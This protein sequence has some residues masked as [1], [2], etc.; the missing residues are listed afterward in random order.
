MRKERRHNCEQA[1]IFNIQRFSLHDGPGIRT[2]V[3]MKGCPLKCFWCANPESQEVN[4]NL[5][6]RNIQCKRCGACINACPHEAIRMGESGER[7]IDW[8]KCDHCLVCVDACIYQSMNRCGEYMGIKEVVDEVIRDEAFYVN[9]GGGV[10]LSGGEP[11]LQI[12][13][14]AQLLKSFKAK[15][16]H[17]AVDTCGFVSGSGIETILPFVDLFLWDIKHL[18]GKKHA[19]STGVSNDRILKNLERVASNKNKIWLRVPLID[20]F[21]DDLEHIR[22]IAGLGKKIGAQKISLLPYH[23]GGKSKCRQIGRPYAWI[24]SGT[25]SQAKIE[26]LKETIEKEGMAAG[27]GN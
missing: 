20:G 2:T 13:F 5:I 4:P 17:T 16:L 18:D 15:G 24:E 7:E 10:T 9:S 22:Q 25:P 27:I 6:V 11:L 21:N 3:F 23:E 12:E 14:A 1:V 19:R 8:E 26:T